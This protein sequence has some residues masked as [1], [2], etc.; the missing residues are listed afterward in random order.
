VLTSI[1][2]SGDASTAVSVEGPSSSTIDGSTT[3]DSTKSRYRPDSEATIGKT[4][5]F[6]L[7]AVIGHGGFGRVYRAYDSQLDR[8]VA[9]KVPKFA[10][11]EKKKIRRFLSEAKAAAG[12]RHPNIVAVF[13][14]GQSNREY[15]I[16]SEFV[17]GRTL[18]DCIR[19][20]RPDFRKS[21]NWILHIANALA[22]AH[23]E[24]IV[25]RDI[26]P[27]NVMIGGN[28]RPQIMDFGLAK[29]LDE[30][31]SMTTEGGLLG[32]PAYMSPEQARG[33]VQNVGPKSDQYS[34]GVILYEVL[35]GKKPFEGPPHSVIAKVTQEEPRTP[36]KINAEIPND[37]QAICLKAME[38]EIDE[39]YADLSEMADDLDRWLA[40]R[41]TLARPINI[42]ERFVRWCRRKPVVAGL[43]VT[44][45]LVLSLGIFVSS[46]FAI[47]AEREKQ[48]AEGE[49]DAAKEAQRKTEEARIQE[50]EA[51]RLATHRLTESYLDRGT[52][53]IQRGLLSEGVHLLV[54]TVEEAPKGADDLVRTARLNLAMIRPQIEGRR[55]C[56][57]HNGRVFA[58][59]ISP[60]GKRCATGADDGVVRVWDLSTRLALT[61]PMRHERR[62]RGNLISSVKFSPD[63]KR[64]LSTSLD[65]TARLWD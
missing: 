32:T 48:L 25:H 4:G 54:R 41:E 27:E 29:R 23:E 53:A 46:Y 2:L 9:I 59:D 57:Y 47:A 49:R 24:G 31:S 40:G 60:D 55:A 3:N 52:S 13:E 43:S 12:L 14:C 28:N 62:K 50:A 37:L 33:D 8:Q 15:Y 35:T 63:G 30:D 10:P 38:K 16:A 5:R 44:L 11:E 17:E 34:L 7:K 56:N 6:E 39:R 22:Y 42:R 1:L 20:E 36:Q 19:S 45:L 51:R 64:L 61:P 58:S 21:A 26:K 65:Q 18:A